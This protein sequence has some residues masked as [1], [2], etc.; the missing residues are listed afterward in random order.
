MGLYFIYEQKQNLLLESSKVHVLII[1]R[2]CQKV[3]KKVKSILIP[4][5]E[6]GVKGFYKFKSNYVESNKII[7]YSS[8]SKWLTSIFA[9]FKEY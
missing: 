5:K 2:Q 3:I 1:K 9:I 6:N 4:K 8:I 7:S